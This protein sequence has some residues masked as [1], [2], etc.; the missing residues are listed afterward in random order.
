MYSLLLVPS[1]H[2]WGIVI[3]CP[4][5]FSV[6]NGSPFELV[7]YYSQGNL[8]RSMKF[9]LVQPCHLYSSSGCLAIHF[10][11]NYQLVKAGIIAK[12]HVTKILYDTTMIKSLSWIS[13]SL[14]TEELAL[15]VDHGMCSSHHQHHVSN[16]SVCTLPNVFIVHNSEP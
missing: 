5:Y 1:A 16:S 12:H 9:D 15:L 7:L 2:G 11:L 8:K 13:S 10:L 6:N 4:S 14:K 3:Q